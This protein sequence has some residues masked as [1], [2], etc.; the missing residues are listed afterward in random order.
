MPDLHFRVESAEPVRYASSP[1]LGL[2]LCVENSGEEEI[3]SIAL[4]CQIR[5][6][7]TRR[8]YTET[9]QRR[10]RDL[11]G[12]PER[13][14]RTLHSL[15]WAHA[16]AV[17]PPFRECTVVELPVAC[18]FDLTV[19]TAKYFDG[20]EGGCAPLTLLFSGTVFYEGAEGGLQVEQIPWSKETTWSL[21]V[22]MWKKMMD[23]HYPNTAWLCLRRDVF[24]RLR[25][26]KSDRGIATWEQTVESMLP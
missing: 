15:L 20:L 18:T 5:I 9:E 25:Q 11:F 22:D 7:T 3:R 17:I 4:Q 6:E 10:L 21:P 8:S 24:D 26:Y 2:R 14:G 1:T 13:W 16:A 19:A 23:A 12:E